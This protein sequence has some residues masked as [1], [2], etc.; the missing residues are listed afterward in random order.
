VWTISSTTSCR[1]MI[2]RGARVREG[3]TLRDAVEARR[4]R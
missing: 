3:E 1:P 2:P 4:A